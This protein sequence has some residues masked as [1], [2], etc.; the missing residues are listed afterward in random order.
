[1]MY[2]RE[3][4]ISSVIAGHADT[5]RQSCRETIISSVIAGHADTQRQS[6]RETIISSVIAGHAD[7]QRQSCRETIISSV[8]AGHADT[9]L[10]EPRKRNSGISLIGNR[11]LG[12]L[13][14]LAWRVYWNDKNITVLVAFYSA[15]FSQW[16]PIKSFTLR[17]W[18]CWNQAGYELTVLD[19]LF[20]Q[21]CLR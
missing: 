2:C 20:R 18:S 11:T 15:V 5:Q 7:T 8:I 13:I 4:M 16:R 21:L 14:L 3:I 10:S 17:S 1:M 9:R 19:S 12:L 6:C